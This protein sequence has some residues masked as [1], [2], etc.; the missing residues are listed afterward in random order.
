MRVIILSLDR[1]SL[2][3]YLFRKQL[4][5]PSQSVRKNSHAFRFWIAIP[6]RLLQIESALDYSVPSFRESLECLSR[7]ERFC[8]SRRLCMSVSGEPVR[9]STSQEVG[10]LSLR[11]S[12]Q[13]TTDYA[14]SMTERLD[15][16]LSKTDL[17]DHANGPCSDPGPSSVTWQER[18]FWHDR[19]VAP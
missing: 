3:K 6:A 12:S 4:Y 17:P 14:T 8:E 15:S 11:H 7:R 13:L 1:K 10:T 16:R 5:R 2:Q 9:T 18:A 19:T